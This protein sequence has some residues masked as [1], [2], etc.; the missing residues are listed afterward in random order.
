MVRGF[1][2]LQITDFTH[3]EYGIVVRASY[4]GWVYKY[5][6]LVEPNGNVK[7]KDGGEWREL[8]EVAAR[9][10]MAKLFS[11]VARASPWIS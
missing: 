7:G 10:I 5:T 9:I 11:R 8:S 2:N 6:F 3:T 1:E 4:P